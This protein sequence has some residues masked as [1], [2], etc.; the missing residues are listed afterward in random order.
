MAFVRRELPTPQLPPVPTVRLALAATEVRLATV[1]TRYS[2]N[3][4]LTLQKYRDWQMPKWTSRASL[5]ST[6]T[7]RARYSS[8]PELCCNARDS[9]NRASWGWIS[10]HRPFL[11]LAGMHWDRG[12]QVMHSDPSNWK[13]RKRWTRPAPSVRLPARKILWV[14]ALPD[15]AT[16][17]R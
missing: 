10:T 17:R 7:R 13:A 14:T 3:F 11:P 5:C 15:S 12:G 8:Y 6:T 16:A 2:W 9:C 1:D 4:V